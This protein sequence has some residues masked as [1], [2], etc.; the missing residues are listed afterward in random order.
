MTQ[1]ASTVALGKKKLEDSC[2]FGVRKSGHG[3][4]TKLTEKLPDQPKN[5][6]ACAGIF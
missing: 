4:I 1:Q 3:F 5:T 6:L 2:Q